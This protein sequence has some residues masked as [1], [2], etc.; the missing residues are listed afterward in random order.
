MTRFLQQTTTTVGSGNLVVKT[1]PSPAL[2]DLAAAASNALTNARLY[3]AK[4]LEVLDGPMG[5]FQKRFAQ[6]YFLTGPDGLTGSNLARVKQVL[7]LT[8][9]GLAS[10]VTIKAG[11]N[12]GKGDGS[13][14][15]VVSRNETKVVSQP[16]HNRFTKTQD[17]KTYTYGAI[18]LDEVRLRTELGAQTLIHEATHKYAG[19][20]DYY[21]F[22]SASG[23]TDKSYSQLSKEKA[24]DNAD[25]YAWFVWHVGRKR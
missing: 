23:A 9:N 21:Y 10:D 12:V 7:L 25:S 13:P 8:R 14:L 11:S 18:R 5:V 24:L 16:Y 17:G 19:T 20:A 6:T 3:L 15:G 4:T 1:M 22:G 2:N